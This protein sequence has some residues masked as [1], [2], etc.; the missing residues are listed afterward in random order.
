MAIW[1]RPLRRVVG[2]AEELLLDEHRDQ[3]AV[4]R[5]HLQDGD[6]HA[7]LTGA[8][9]LLAA[10]PD[11]GQALLLAG[12]AQLQLHDGV[13][14]AASL[15]RATELRED[16]P[17]AWL[18]LAAAQ[19]WLGEWDAAIVSSSRAVNLA[20]GDRALLAEAYGAR[21]I[22]YRFAGEREKCVRE[23]RKAI[24]EAAAAGEG[25][26]TH[27][28][29]LAEALATSA[30]VD[31]SGAEARR[32]SG[33]A[34]GRPWGAIAR[35]RLALAEGN[36]E[37]A[38]DA[39]AEAEGAFDNAA[40]A[41][42][43]QGVIEARIGRG[44]SAL[45]MGDSV[46]AETFFAA[47][48]E[49][50]PRNPRI[51]QW[52]ARACAV[53]DSARALALYDELLRDVSRPASRDSG[54]PAGHVPTAVLTNAI[55]LALEQA[56]AAMEAHASQAEVAAE[57]A[58]PPL[59]QSELTRLAQWSDALLAR[60]PES[61]IALCAR[62]VAMQNDAMVLVAATRGHAL[63][64]AWLAVRALAH[65]E[66][67]AL[68]GSLRQLDTLLTSPTHEATAALHSIRT[69][70]VRALFAPT[71]PT[72]AARVDALSRWLQ[73]RPELV[74]FSAQLAHAVADLDQPLWLTV[75]G[76]FSS[77][78][79]SFVNAFIGHDV[80]PTGVTPTT[81]TIHVLRYGRER[82]A[83]IFFRDGRTEAVA[84]DELAARLR[85]ISEDEARTILRVDMLMPLPILQTISIVDTP[86]LNSI[87]AEHEDV[88]RGFITK[89][90]AVI[91]LFT[92]GQVGKATEREALRSIVAAGRRVLGVLNKTDQFSAS[93]CA[94]A[95]AF[96]EREIGDC[97]EA[98]VPLS[99]RGALAGEATSGWADLQHELDTRF[100]A[101]ARELKMAAFTRRVREVTAL[102]ETQYQAR[103]VATTVGAATLERARQALLASATR[104]QQRI[105]DEA[106]RRYTDATNA[107]LRQ[108]AKEVEGLVVPR[109]LPF[110]QASASP[111]DREYVA[112]MLRDGYEAEFAAMW[113]TAQ[114]QLMDAWRGVLPT[115]LATPSNGSAAA[116]AGRGQ[117]GE[118]SFA[119]TGDQVTD[120]AAAAARDMATLFVDQAATIR[121]T[122][123]RAT[124][125]VAGYWD[126]GH[127]ATFFADDLPRHSGSQDGL[128]LALLRYSPDADELVT[129]PVARTVAKANAIIA[130]RLARWVEIANAVSS[131]VVSGELAI[132]RELEANTGAT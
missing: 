101:H 33:R 44:E 103:V 6:A 85:R 73:D 102:L 77:G 11:H 4:I 117:A 109:A 3:V 119:T 123:E 104:M 131:S 23:L 98:I 46:A 20:E 38:A 31:A 95:L 24:A 71:E 43:Q 125:Y 13:A 110:T 108:A 57:P 18:G 10:R 14:A 65:G 48:G 45:R 100:F 127:L 9:S 79:S 12:R 121:E 70:V 120:F 42:A 88:A 86:G 1:S 64:I 39:F 61:A 51:V 15:L 68:R 32:H 81:A 107:L 7:A 47:A 106:T 97:V 62:G 35:G 22:G 26:A 60:E 112:A 76:E 59:G 83:H 114:A 115:E 75:M 92:A 130:A 94:D 58:A 37:A 90:D 28:A 74:A 55:T 67:S 82:G 56:V 89:A 63:A 99:T 8:E 21:G 2:L 36:A 52:M 93:E 78:K 30:A 25:D 105:V 69:R 5:Q 128:F 66:M 126:G 40:G 16:D 41:L 87:L 129:E 49:L 96:A 91:W 80:A 111:A 72:P 50:A 54:E 122:M 124:A 132:L 19:L 116:V 53:H 118:A 17:R 27:R 29:H 84:W 113:Q 34:G